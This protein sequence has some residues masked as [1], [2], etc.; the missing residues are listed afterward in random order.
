MPKRLDSKGFTLIE[1]L[2]SAAILA[3]VV[4]LASM[5]FTQGFRNSKTE[6]NRD[7]SVTIARSIMEEIKTNLPTAAEAIVF[8][9]QTI[10]LKSIRNAAAG[11][12]A[13]AS[14]NIR[15][16]KET[17]GIYSIIVTAAPSTDV[18]QVEGHAFPLN[19]YFRKVKVSV[20][21][22]SIQSEY[23]LESYIEYNKPAK[24]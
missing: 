19:G 2:A 9:S 10:S 3:F 22:S 7:Q 11:P 20:T 21:E 17:D 12:V 1:A 6:E 4:I 15:Y 5:L 8:G 16:P 23:A 14:F 24:E 13:V 18:V